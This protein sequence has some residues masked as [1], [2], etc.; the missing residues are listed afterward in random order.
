M[1][2]RRRIATAFKELAVARGLHGV[3]MDEL[4]AHAG[5]SKKTIYRHFRS[6]EEIVALLV[7]ELL[8][9]VATRVQQAL[10]LSDSPVD[11]V[12]HLIETV[13]RDVKPLA[14]L[15][16]HD[17]QKYYPHLWEK[18]E[19]FRAEKIQRTFEDLLRE[20]P[21]GCFRPVNP[22][23]FTAALIA[24]VRAVVNPA[25]IMENNLSP[26]ETVRSLFA[27][28]MYGVVADR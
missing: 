15:L 20:D 8:Q 12:A 28:F 7:E 16:L 26:E 9:S 19:R 13:V 2:Y 10:A 6:K 14:P 24:S 22:K 17:L 3:T 1:D 11:R 4:A 23:I 18:I 21:Q 25:F 5:L 27:I